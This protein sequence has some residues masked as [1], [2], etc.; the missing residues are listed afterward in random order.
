MTTKTIDDALPAAVWIDTNILVYAN[1]A[2]SPF[3]KLAVARLRAYDQSN[4]ALWISRQ[5]LREYISAMT[6][7]NAL[8]ATISLS[9][10]V[11]DVRYF[12]ARFSLGEDGAQITETL[13]ELI[14]RFPTGGR[15]VYDA[16]I[17]ATMLRHSVHHLLTHNVKDF[18][19]FASEIT[20]LPLDPT[21]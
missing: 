17:V 12:A 7:R 5:T 16:N 19:R 8:T 1:L 13:L 4:C 15:P 11:A 3:H 14:T 10:V 21:P 2:L 9:S 6:R 20:I 18:S